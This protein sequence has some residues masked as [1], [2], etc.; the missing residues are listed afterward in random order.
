MGELVFVGLGLEDES[1]ISL[2]GLEEARS[3]DKVFI[4]TYTSLMPSLSIS[5][6]EQMINHKICTVT[7]NNI[8]DNSGKEVLAAAKKGKVVLLVPGDPLI[9]TTHVTLRIDASK[10]GI[11]SRIIHGAS[12]LSAAIGM[13]G[14]H[15]YKFGK[16]V[17]IPFP[18][19]GKADTPYDVIAQNKRIGLHTLCF[20]DIKTEERKYLGIQNAIGALEQVETYK[21]KLLITEATLVIGLARIGSIKPVAKAENISVLRH[22]DFGDPPYTMIFP[23]KLHFMEAEALVYL[24]GAPVTLVEDTS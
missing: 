9:A 11:S 16:S 20:L 3:A 15:N 2:K 14:L 4:E 22:F 7:R 19:E 18:D 23:G 6:L 12:I 21:K 13:S 5:T 10:L 17:T 8:E 24:C 1:G